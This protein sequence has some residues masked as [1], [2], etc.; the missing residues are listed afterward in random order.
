MAGRWEVPEPAMEFG[1]ANNET[2]SNRG[3]L[4]LKEDIG[5][6]R[7]LIE[8]PSSA[9]G[10][11]SRKH[12]YFRKSFANPRFIFHRSLVLKSCVALNLSHI[13]RTQGSHV[14]TLVAFV[15]NNLYMHL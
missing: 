1:K 6:K 8:I 7:W 15:M 2:F 14:G 9:N 5:N 13:S 12:I 3:F 4:V 11:S 10:H